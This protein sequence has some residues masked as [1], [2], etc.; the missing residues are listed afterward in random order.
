M[1]RDYKLIFRG[2]LAAD[3]HL[4]VV[5]KR[6][7]KLLK[8]NDQTLDALFSGQAVVLRKSIDAAGAA[9]FQAA[10]KQAGARLRVQANFAAATASPAS[11]PPSEALSSAGAEIEGSRGE[12][13]WHLLPVGSLMLE[14]EERPSAVMATVDIDHL[15]LAEPGATLGSGG[16]PVAESPAIVPDFALAEPGALLVRGTAESVA[17]APNTAHLELVPEPDQD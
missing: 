13:G 5:R 8:A 11:A 6:L 9:K 2:E 1:S 7:G 10:F 4:A 3:Q 12:Q 16:G 15:T 17:P 14:V